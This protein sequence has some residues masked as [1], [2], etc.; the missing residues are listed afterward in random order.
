MR[1]VLAS[2]NKGKLRELQ[3]ILGQAGLELIPVDD[4]PEVGEVEETG[5]TFLDNARLKAHTVA[6]ATGLPA[7]ADDSGLAV[8]ALG[9]APGVFSARWAGE[10]ADDKDN[11]KKLLAEMADVE[12]GKRQA[13][14]VCVLVLAWPNGREMAA[15]AEFRGEIAL[16]PRGENGFGYDPVFFV[17]E[18]NATVAELPAEKKNA[19][20]H[21]AKAAA[22]LRE[23]LE[24]ANLGE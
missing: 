2:R 20:S 12:P 13:A 5:Q 4:F 16:E 9:G 15:R 11:W 18:L 3:D 8:D 6:R 7:L 21:R 10:F 22:R 19:I 23:L 1:V 14:F 17:P 24:K